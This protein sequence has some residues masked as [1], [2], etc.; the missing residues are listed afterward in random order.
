MASR[1]S[2]HRKILSCHCGLKPKI[3]YDT[4]DKFTLV[5]R[6][7]GVRSKSHDIRDKAVNNWNKGKRFYYKEHEVH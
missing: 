3:M 2:K 4:K 5:C 6:N 1:E 7:C